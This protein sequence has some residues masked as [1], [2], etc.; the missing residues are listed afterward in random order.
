M[1]HK[2]ELDILL[3]QIKNMIHDKPVVHEFTSESEDLEN[4]QEALIYLSSCLSESNEFV[5]QLS[6]GNLDATIPSRHNFLS[7]GLKELNAGLKH[8]TWQANQV[9]SGD[10][11]QRVSFLGELSVSF[12]KMITQLDERELQ[13]KQQSS[14]LSKTNGLMKSIMDGLKDWIIVTAKDSGEVIYTNQSARQLFYNPD[15]REHIC[16]KSCGLMARL[17][18][19]EE[20][21]NEDTTFDYTCP[22]S[23]QTLRARTFL[24]QWNESL[25]YVHYILDIT[26]EQEQLEQMEE[27]AYKDELTN[28]YNRRYCVGKLDYL[29]SHKNN[30]SFC[31][32]DV[33]GLK[34]AN[35]N[36]GHGAGDEYLKKVA[37]EMMKVIREKDIICRFGGDE[38]A[39]IFPLCTASLV[40]NKMD[41]LNEKL[42]TIQQLYPMSI[43][44][45]VVYVEEDKKVVS[46]TIM[47][48]ADKK[49]YIQKK[50][51]KQT[52]YSVKK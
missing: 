51:K 42:K 23:N 46:E 43:S 39:I 15:K 1:T 37:Q 45:G 13:L 52:K 6:I 19:A 40:L 14:R 36:F 47:A 24:I 11:N 26:H 50:L 3:N 5:K 9:A 12:N 41:Y 20:R 8:L 49:M 44:Y 10:Y 18:L 2:K 32:I 17:K 30:F 35:D 7:G 31:M 29:L 27:L 34:F 21:N 38:F 48:Q 16:G 25:A 22:V 28:L 33:D 4:I